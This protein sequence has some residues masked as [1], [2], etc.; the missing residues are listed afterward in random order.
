MPPPRI[1]YSL[2]SRV[3][4]SE[5]RSGFAFPLAGGGIESEFS[6]SWVSSL[7]TRLSHKRAPQ[8]LPPVAATI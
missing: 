6:T 3:R 4:L 2:V 1:T 7:K 5:G 8:L